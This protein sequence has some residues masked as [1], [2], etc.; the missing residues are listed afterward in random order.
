MRAASA[1]IKNAR[2]L[3]DAIARFIVASPAPLRGQ[4]VRFL[5][6][7]LKVSQDGLAKILGQKRGS[8]ARW[9]GAPNKAIPGYANRA[10]R[11]FFAL[12][13]DGHELGK[14]LVELVTELDELEHRRPELQF[15]EDHGWHRKAA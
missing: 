2:G 7:M 12:N 8:V 1:S 5:R 3:H 11:Y 9:E 13:P 15:E 6:S 14:K 10:L 4:E